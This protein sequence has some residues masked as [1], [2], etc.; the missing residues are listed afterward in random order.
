MQGQFTYTAT[1]NTSNPDNDRLP[2][3][4]LH[5][6]SAIISYQPIDPFRLN[7]EFRYVGQRFNDANNTQSLP[8]FDVWN[9]AATYDI[10]RQVQGYLRVDNLFERHYEELLYFGTPGRSVFGG[11]RVNFNLL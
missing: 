11:I 9:L 7:L 6:Y 10:N 3:W 1:R 8:S 5:Q 4:P 2:R